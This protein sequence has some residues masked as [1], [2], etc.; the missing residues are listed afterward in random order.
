MPGL[1]EAEQ[2]RLIQTHMDLVPKIAANFRGRKSIPFEDLV[3]AGMVGLVDSARR[4]NPTSVTAFSSWVTYRITGS[5][6]NFIENWAVMDSLDESGVV[7]ED[8]CWWQIWGS[9]PYE[10]WTELPATPGELRAWYEDI[11][12]K[13]DLL[14]AALLS[15]SRRE[16]NMVRDFYVRKLPLDQVAREYKLSYKKTSKVIKAL[17]T[18]LRKIVL[19]IEQ[20]QNSRGPGNDTGTP[21]K[22]IRGVSRPRPAGTR[23]GARLIQ[24]AKEARGIVHE[25]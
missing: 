24:S 25:M 22:A 21:L 13:S 23:F 5:I 16:R 8:F 10:G 7:E 6:K 14:G 17:V 4:F 9:L 15:L 19:T 1:T 18:K 11:Q 12:D 3:S 20:K 2:N